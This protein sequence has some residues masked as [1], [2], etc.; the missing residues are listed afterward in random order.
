MRRN[1]GATISFRE[2]SYSTDFGALSKETHK[3]A[4]DVNNI[5]RVNGSS[6]FA[7]S[8]NKNSGFVKKILAKL[9]D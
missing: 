8:V 1:Q 3:I 4:S 5:V 2:N 7:L 6:A 9:R